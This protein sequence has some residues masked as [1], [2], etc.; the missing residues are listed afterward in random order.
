MGA[1]E[2]LQRTGAALGVFFP[3]AAAPLRLGLL[4]LP[5]SSTAFPRRFR[6]EG[7]GWEVSLANKAKLPCRCPGG[8][9]ALPGPSA[10]EQTAKLP[11]LGCHSSLQHLERR[12]GRGREEGAVLRAQ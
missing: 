5:S 10:M 4:V 7:A 8:S 9:S 11:D 6:G 1:G 2:G 3:P 12:A